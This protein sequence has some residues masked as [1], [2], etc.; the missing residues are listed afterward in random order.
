MPPS[1]PEGASSWRFEIAP[2]GRSATV[3]TPGPATITRMPNGSVCLTMT[4]GPQWFAEQPGPEPEWTAELAER[5]LRRATTSGSV[6]MR[7]LVDAGGTITRQQLI[8]Q[9]GLPKPEHA[10]QSLTTAARAVLNDVLPGRNEGAAHRHFFQRRRI[11]DDPKGRVHDYHLPA[12]LLP[13]FREA[14]DTLG[15]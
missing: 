7:A 2:D 15:C 12:E 3:H 4:D 6:F 5:I 10:T 1:V 8:E 13:P 14:L 9:T 11:P